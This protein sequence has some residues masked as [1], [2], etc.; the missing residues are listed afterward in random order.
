VDANGNR[1]ILPGEYKLYLGGGQPGGELKT[2]T[3]AFTINGKTDL[4]K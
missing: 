3:A 2:A 1:V 4:P